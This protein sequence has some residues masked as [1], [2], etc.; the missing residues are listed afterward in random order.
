MKTKIALL[1]P[2]PRAAGMWELEQ[3]AKSVLKIMEKAATVEEILK[4]SLI[5]R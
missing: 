1:L 2:V 4:K 5:V 3:T